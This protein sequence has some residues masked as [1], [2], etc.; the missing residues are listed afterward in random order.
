[1]SDLYKLLDEAE[2][3]LEKYTNSAR[4]EFYRGQVLAYNKAIDA[5]KEMMED[6]DDKP[7][8]YSVTY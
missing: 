3:N 4:E 7:S 6:S 1:M 5:V 8:R 2:L